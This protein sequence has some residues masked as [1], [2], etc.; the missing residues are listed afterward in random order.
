MIEHVF[1]NAKRG[2]IW[3]YDVICPEIG[4]PPNPDEHQ[5]M[6][7]MNERDYRL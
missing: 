6:R 2:Y 4:E 7:K 5:M 3:L 1:L